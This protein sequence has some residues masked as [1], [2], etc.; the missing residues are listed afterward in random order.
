[1]CPHCQQGFTQSTSLNRHLQSKNACLTRRGLA[2]SKSQT[3]AAGGEGEGK[4]SMSMGGVAGEEPSSAAVGQEGS[5]PL[6]SGMGGDGVGDFY[7]DD[8]TGMK[9]QTES[10]LLTNGQGI[11]RNH[12]LS[13]SSVADAAVAGSAPASSQP[14]CFDNRNGMAVVRGANKTA[15]IKE[16]QIVNIFSLRSSSQEENVPRTSMDP[17][18]QFCFPVNGEDATL[19]QPGANHV[20]KDG[21]F[22]EGNLPTSTS[23][24]LQSSSA[25][26]GMDRAVSSAALHMVGSLSDAGNSMMPL[27]PVTVVTGYQ[28]VS[29]PAG[30]LMAMRN[31]SHPAN[32][33]HPHLSP[34]HLPHSHGQMH[35]Q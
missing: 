10:S 25:P 8:L 27:P 29:S 33:F 26:T 3:P 18:Q 35:H 12:F 11:N 2:S 19:E 24:L 6:S 4:A 21:I 23:V 32:F 14:H 13:P 1:M 7:S 30:S 20:T 34:P 28:G 22:S 15:D 9:L 31:L 17:T 5:K 16:L